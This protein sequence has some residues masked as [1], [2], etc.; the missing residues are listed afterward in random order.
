MR[1]ALI[2]E[3]EELLFDTL[4]RRSRV[5]TE[6]LV[7]EGVTVPLDDVRRAHAGVPALAALAAIP[8]YGRLDDVGQALVLRRYA[9]AVTESFTRAV[10]SFDP[11]VHHTIELLASEFPLGIVTRAERG[12]AQWLLEQTGLDACFT[13]I[14]SLADVHASAQQLAWSEVF[15]RLLADRGAAFAS[16]NMLPGAAE[17]GLQTVAVGPGSCVVAR[18]EQRPFARVDTA[19]ITSLF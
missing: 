14:R 3:I 11:S 4:D 9:D 5:L 7:R 17:A 13:T 10:P 15:S 16:A 19:F 8:A 18:G 12:D 1:T 6:S 2:I